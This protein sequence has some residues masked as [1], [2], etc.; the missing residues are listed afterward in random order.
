MV[1]LTM[2]PITPRFTWEVR[3]DW[4]GTRPA[5][6]DEIIF[7]CKENIGAGNFSNFMDNS[8][9]TIQFRNECD[10]TLFK[11]RFEGKPL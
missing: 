4:L 11:L 6:R 5:W 2:S 10:A 3:L 1:K 7:W 8:S 9:E